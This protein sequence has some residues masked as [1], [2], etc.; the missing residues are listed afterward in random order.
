V[1]LAWTTIVF[2]ILPL[3]GFLFFVGLYFHERI[4]RDVAPGSPLGQLAGAVL[5]AFVIHGGF[6]R[7]W[8]RRAPPRC[9]ACAWITSWPCFSSKAPATSR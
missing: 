1:S 7:F 6:S 8:E 2:L 3:P 5:T 9:R 4:S